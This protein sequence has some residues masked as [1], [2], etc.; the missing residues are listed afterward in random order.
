VATKFFLTDAAPSTLT[1]GTGT[2]ACDIAAGSAQVNSDATATALGPTTLNVKKG[3]QQLLWTSKPVNAFTINGT[4]TLNIWMLESNLAANAGARVSVDIFNQAG[5]FLSNVIGSSKGT[6]LPTT[7]AAQNW[8]Q[9]PSG[10]GG[11]AVPQ[12]AIIVISLAFADAGGTMAAGNTV[13]GSYSG[14]TGGANGD[15]Y[16]TFVENITFVSS[17][18]PAN[19]TPPSITGTPQVGSL[20]VANNGAW[21]GDPTFAYQWNNNGTPISGAIASTYTPVTNDLADNLT[22]TVTGTNAS[23]SAAATSAAVG[24]VTAA[25]TGNTVAPVVSGSVTVGGVLSCTTGTWSPTPS[26]F[27]YQ[28]QTSADGATNWTNIA[29]AAVN[30]YTVQAGNVGLYIRCA[31]TAS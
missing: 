2:R 9:V 8:T 19:T 21:T 23:G 11:I 14:P 1:L 6:E 22:V 25:S 17:G 16:V 20:L 7:V 10:G 27:A 4:L 3:G 30:T 26:S 31:V 12:G 13:T 24:P 18:A 5:V 15:S 29:G 28:W